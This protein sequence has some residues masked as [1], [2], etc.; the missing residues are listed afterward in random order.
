MHWNFSNGV[1]LHISQRN[2]N[3]ETGHIQHIGVACEIQTSSCMDMC[4]VPGSLMAQIW[5]IKFKYC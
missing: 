3:K 4:L 1:F 2:H 5:G